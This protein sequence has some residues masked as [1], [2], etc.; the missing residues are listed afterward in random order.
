MPLQAKNTVI[1]DLLQSKLHVKRNSARSYAS[2]LRKLFSLVKSDGTMDNLRFL[3]TDEAVKVVASLSPASRKKNMA[4]AALSGARAAEFSQKRMNQYREIMLTADQQY[5]K[6]ARSGV[7]K[8]F[9]GSAKEHWKAITSMHKTISRVV[10]SR[11]L[12]KRQGLNHEEVIILQQLVYARLLAHFE[13]RRLEY[14]TL[15]FLSP[16][17]IQEIGDTSSFNYIRTGPKQWTLVYNIYKTSKT[18]GRQ[19]YQVPSGFRTVLKKVQRSLA[20]VEPSGIIFFNRSG[21]QMGF[22]AFSQFIKNTFKT[23]L[24]RSF[25]QNTVRSIYISSVFA[26]LPSTEKLLDM[27]KN[28][29]SAITTQLT[30][31]RVPQKKEE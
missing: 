14:V 7:R 23:Y 20:L 17:Q 28:M 11:Q 6:Y 29:G 10:S 2:Q 21:R 16:E 12:Y 22:S 31:Y 15:R 19:E 13:P 30:H 3:D 25:T 4:V 9:T 26:G 5:L 18:Y 24:N 27:Q 8:K 1:T